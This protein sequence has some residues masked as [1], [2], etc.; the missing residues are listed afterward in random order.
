MS[1]K[2]LTE[3]QERFIDFYIATG[4]ASEAARRAGY[5]EGSIPCASKW[6]N[7]QESQFKPYLKAAIDSRLKE[8]ESERVADAKEVMQFL[9]SAMRGETEEEVIIVESVGEGLSEARV[10]TKHLSGRDRLD[11]AKQLAKRY[12][13][14][15]AAI[16]NIDE[17]P[18]IL[19][20]G[21]T[22]SVIKVNVPDIVGGGYG[23]FW[24]WRG[25]YRVV[26]GSR[27]SKKSK[28]TALW[29]IY[30]MMKYPAANLLVVRKVARTL[31]NSCF[32]DLR[33]AIERLH[34]GRYWKA[35]RSPMEITFLPTGQRIL[36]AGL[37]DPLKITSISVPKGVL[38]WMWLNITGSH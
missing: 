18:V 1:R 2:G 34:V 22:L 13:L 23:T 21:V 3:K 29:Y 5:S 20:G 4:N 19:E 27:A 12:G 17:G 24:R 15:S 16:E 30:N 31:Q 33:W 35:T 32:S 7:P 36:F 8:L 10:M 6:I 28:T 38:C 14:D 26:K 11:A 37:D 25:R 9:T